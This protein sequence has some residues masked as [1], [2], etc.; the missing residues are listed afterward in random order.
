[1]LIAT[2]FNALSTM[3]TA[4]A[5][6]STRNERQMKLPKR[7]LGSCRL[8]GALAAE[9]RTSCGPNSAR[10]S[11]TQLLPS[12]YPIHH[13]HDRRYLRSICPAHNRLA[14]ER[15]YGGAFIRRQVAERNGEQR[16]P[17]N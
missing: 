8:A 15:V 14:A 12:T 16:P 9:T 17:P 6:R 2:G 4:R 1:M 10:V 7:L 3:I 5:I 13:S 11:R